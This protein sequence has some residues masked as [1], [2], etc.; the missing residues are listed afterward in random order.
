MT[1]ITDEMLMAY[2][3]GE[4]DAAARADIARAVAADAVLRRRLALFDRS[5]NQAKEAFGAVLEEPIPEALL[6]AVRDGA[7]PP[8]TRVRAPWLRFLLLPAALAAAAVVGF[9]A[10]TTITGPAPGGYP[11][12]AIAA[13]SGALSTG[14]TAQLADATV[15]VAGTYATAEGYCRV[16]GIVQEAEGWR[17]IACGAG[18]AWSVRMIVADSAIAAGGYTPASGGVAESIDAF[19][20]GEGAGSPLDAGAE[21]A[22]MA[23]N[24]LPLPRE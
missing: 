1:G 15:T 12:V 22:A 24:W 8:A 6:A 3:D 16:L 14:E 13:A 7:T 9:V 10:A 4:L 23:G 17:A 5:R 20:D 11:P 21:A 19:L 18:G 2:A